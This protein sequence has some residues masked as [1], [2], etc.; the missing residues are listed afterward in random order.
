MMFSSNDRTRAVQKVIETLKS[1]EQFSMVV[2]SLGH[3]PVSLMKNANGNH[4]AQRCL[5]H[6]KPVHTEVRDI[7][8]RKYIFK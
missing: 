2:S 1:V 4:V 7:C 6:L 8:F 3:D 5:Q